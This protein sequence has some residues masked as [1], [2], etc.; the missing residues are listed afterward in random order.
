MILIPGPFE[1]SFP[2]PDGRFPPTNESS[3]PDLEKRAALKEGMEEPVQ[4]R[5]GDFNSKAYFRK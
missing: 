2:D 4:I 5:A 1:N 3:I